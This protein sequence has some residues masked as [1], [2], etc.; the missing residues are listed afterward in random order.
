MRAAVQ[1][2]QRGCRNPMTVKRRGGGGGCGQ[3]VRGMSGL[4]RRLG[5]AAENGGKKTGK[6]A[7]RAAAGVVGGVEL[8]LLLLDP[9]VA[10][11]AL[12]RSSVQ[13]DQEATSDGMWRGARQS[14]EVKAKR[15]YGEDVTDLDSDMIPG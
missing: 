9:T 8:G 10:V 1:W 14:C 3:R 6:V 2:P 12:R 13:R 5:G 11:V 15:V 4:A 7:H